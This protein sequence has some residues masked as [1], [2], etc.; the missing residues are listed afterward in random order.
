L[1]YARQLLSNR[2]DKGLVVRVWLHTKNWTPDPDRPGK[3][4]RWAD[5]DF[6]F[7]DMLRC[8]QRDTGVEVSER[9]VRGVVSK[10]CREEFDITSVHQRPSQGAMKH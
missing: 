1:A 5:G 3:L 2:S 6:T 10:M 4:R 9:T 8:I 7:K